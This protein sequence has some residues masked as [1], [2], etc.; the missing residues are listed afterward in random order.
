MFLDTF[1]NFPANGSFQKLA[2][3][4]KAWSSV[5][6]SSPL[7]RGSA[8]LANFSDFPVE[9]VFELPEEETAEVQ[10]GLFF[11]FLFRRFEGRCLVR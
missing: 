11:N 9:L 5:I 6:S 7:E 4:G 3:P 8:R 1:L 10:M 2:H